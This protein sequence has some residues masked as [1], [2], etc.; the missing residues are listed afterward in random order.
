MSKPQFLSQ[1]SRKKLQNS[2]LELDE[3]F[4]LPVRCWAH[5]FS[6]TELDGEEVQRELRAPA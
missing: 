5:Q 1:L 6:L 4:L 2:T 3:S